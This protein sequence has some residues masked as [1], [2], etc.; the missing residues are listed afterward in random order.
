MNIMGSIFQFE[1][2]KIVQKLAHARNV[3][4]KEAG[5]RI[6]GAKP[7]DQ[8]LRNR[9]KQLRRKKKGRSNRM[10]FAKIAVQMNAEGFVSKQGKAINANIVKQL[11][12]TPK[13][14]A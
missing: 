11:L 8:K 5:H 3:K 2:M 12:I 14:A 1:K 13:K 7:S 10:S 9:A 4:S 6:E